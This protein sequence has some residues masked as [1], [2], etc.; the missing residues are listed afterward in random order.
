M[1]KILWSNL[2]TVLPTLVGIGIDFIRPGHLGSALGVILTFLIGVKL[3]STTARD[4][5]NSQREHL[6]F[7]KKVEAHSMHLASKGIGYSINGGGCN[8]K[9]LGKLF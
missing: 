9:S 4:A 8:G 2:L 1:K 3:S 7:K 5:A 6:A